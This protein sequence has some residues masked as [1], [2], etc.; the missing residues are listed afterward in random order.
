MCKI[1][2]SPYFQPGVMMIASCLNVV[3]SSL[4]VQNGSAQKNEFFYFSFC[5]SIL[6]AISNGV[7]TAQIYNERRKT[8]V[9]KLAVE[10]LEEIV[11]QK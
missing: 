10:R 8:F 3:G 2:N 11:I 7:R 6:Y 1:L 5:T 4:A 9:E